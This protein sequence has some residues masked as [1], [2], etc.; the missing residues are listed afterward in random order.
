MPLRAI[1]DVMACGDVW[2]TTICG[3]HYR[4]TEPASG[5]E[6]QLW[7]FPHRHGARDANFTAQERSLAMVAYQVPSATA[8]ILKLILR[9]QRHDPYKALYYIKVPLPSKCK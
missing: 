8:E 3:P 2:S 4:D 9:Q 6:A 7:G 5:C 1:S